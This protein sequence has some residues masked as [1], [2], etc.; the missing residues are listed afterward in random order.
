MSSGGSASPAPLQVT[1]AQIANR[2]RNK[3]R[4]QCDAR[5]AG[6]AAR[7]HRNISR[8]DQGTPFAEQ[9]NE[10]ANA[11]VPFDHG[12]IVYFSGSAS[13]RLSVLRGQT[14]PASCEPEAL[15]ATT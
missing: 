2:I 6:R 9:R 3:S 12:T 13:D 14:M 4:L 7:L 11:L 5:R 1:R 10:A 15:R 8:D